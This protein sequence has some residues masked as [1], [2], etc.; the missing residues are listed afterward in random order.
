MKVVASPQKKVPRISSAVDGEWEDS[1]TFGT[2]LGEECG[3]VQVKRSN[4]RYQRVNWPCKVDRSRTRRWVI[5]F[6]GKQQTEN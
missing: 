2:K 4:T 1:A 5:E 6:S 3:V